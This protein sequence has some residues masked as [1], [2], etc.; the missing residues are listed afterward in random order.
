MRSMMTTIT[1]GAITCAIGLTLLPLSASAQSGSRL[2]GAA[3]YL[4]TG[5]MGVMVE[6]KQPGSSNSRK[7][8]DKFCNSLAQGIIDGF[9]AEGL[10][11]SESN[12]GWFKRTECEGVA[13]WMSGGVNRA[14]I[15][16]QM[17]RTSVGNG[18]NPYVV[19]YNKASN[20]F[21]V[22]KQ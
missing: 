18:A 7:K 1:A 20:T 12:R 21:S 6:I 9:E 8:A 22:T 4:P 2:C 15:C 5:A 13:G 11:V 17:E 14:D 10:N 19:M 16:D 3:V